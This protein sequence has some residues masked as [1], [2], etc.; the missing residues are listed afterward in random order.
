M[1][2]IILLT[3]LQVI[4]FIIYLLLEFSEIRDKIKQSE[5]NI[6]TAIRNEIPSKSRENDK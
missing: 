6:I 2:S 1:Q 3:F 4:S 5:N